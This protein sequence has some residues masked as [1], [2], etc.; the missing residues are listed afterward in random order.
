MTELWLDPDAGET[1]RAIEADAVR[2][3]LAHR[4]NDVLDRLESNPGD[5]S[6]RRHRFYRPAL[7]C[8]L[9]EAQGEDW[10]VLWEPHPTQAD[11]VI[12]R[13]LGP[14]SFT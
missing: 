7:W 5:A 3:V 11:D 13:Y 4:L 1:L 14:A 8:V 9:V 2:S 12:V 10:A 6:L